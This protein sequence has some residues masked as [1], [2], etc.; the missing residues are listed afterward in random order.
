MQVFTAVP[1][2]LGCSRHNASDREHRGLWQCLDTS[3]VP[4]STSLAV[5]KA[6]ISTCIPT[7]KLGLALGPAPQS[8]THS[9]KDTHIRNKA[10]G[11]LR[12][13]GGGIMN[14]RTAQQTTW[15]M[16]WTFTAIGYFLKAFSPVLRIAIQWRF[17]SFAHGTLRLS[18]FPIDSPRRLPCSRSLPTSW[19]PRWRT[20]PLLRTRSMYACRAR[21]GRCGP[22]LAVSGAVTSARTNPRRVRSTGI[23]LPPGPRRWTRL[24]C[25]ACS[26][27]LRLPVL[28]STRRGRRAEV[29]VVEADELEDGLMSPKGSERESNVSV[30]DVT[31]RR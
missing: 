12:S 22:P 20:S 29:S 8:K 19:L 9:S 15:Q 10:S 11:M 14:P 25:A 27:R 23:R 5:G 4:T 2:W 7:G 3:L 18:R 16:P 26:S 13:L 24:W 17:T 31:L 21:R 1:F 28:T 30:M 6:F